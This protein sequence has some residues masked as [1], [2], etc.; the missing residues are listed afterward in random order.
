[1]FYKVIC[2]KIFIITSKTKTIHVRN[3]RF[4]VNVKWSWNNCYLQR[5]NEWTSEWMNKWMSGSWHLGSSFF[6]SKTKSLAFLRARR[7]K[8]LIL[9]AMKII[10]FTKQYKHCFC[11]LNSSE[12]DSKICR[13]VFLFC[14]IEFAISYVCCFFF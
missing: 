3:V 7:Y 8:H 4:Q 9:N 2:Y 10:I 11:S 12:G 1:M 13:V 6:L 14:F 5:M